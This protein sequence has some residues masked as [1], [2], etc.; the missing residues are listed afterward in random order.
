[1]QALSNPALTDART[2]H[3]AQRSLRLDRDDVQLRGQQRARQLAGSGGQIEHACTAREAKLC[4]ECADHSRRVLRAPALVV[5]GDRRKALREG[6][7]AHAG[8]VSSGRAHSGGA[9]A[10]CPP[11]AAL[12]AQPVAVKTSVP[13]I[14]GTEAASAS[15]GRRNSDS[16]VPSE[17]QWWYS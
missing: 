17:E 10:G 11:A 7:K 1:G 15:R 2:E 4:C 5:I 9:P 3:L 8:S 12:D 6:V 13:K 16:Q 14:P